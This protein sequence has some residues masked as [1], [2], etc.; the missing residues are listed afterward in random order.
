MP[1][2]R[3]S[4]PAELPTATLWS[5]GAQILKAKSAAAVHQIVVRAAAQ[6]CAAPSAVWW[7][8]SGHHLSARSTQGITLSGPARTFEAPL[9]LLKLTDGAGPAFQLSADQ[10]VHSAFLERVSAN[11]AVLVPARDGR[12]WF[13]ILSVHDGVFDQSRLDLLA[14]LAQQAAIA[15]RSLLLAAEARQLARERRSGAGEFGTAFMSALSLDE[16]LSVICR[17]SGGSGNVD[18]CLIFFAEDKGAPRLRAHLGDLGASPDLEAALLAVADSV[19]R[20]P[21]GLVVWHEGDASRSAVRSMLEG[22][23]FRSLLGLALSIRGE[24]LGALLLLRKREQGFSAHQQR[25]LLLFATQAAVAIENIQ[26]FEST[27]RRLLEVADL[28]WVG[29]RI[30]ASHDVSTIAAVVGDAAA[31][32]LDAP[33]VALFLEQEDGRF[34]AIPRSGGRP[35]GDGLVLDARGHIGAEALLAASPLAIAD[36]EEEGRTHDPLVELL[37]ARALLC[38][39]MTVQHGLRGFFVIA[40]DRPRGFRSHD[41]GVLSNYSNQAALALQSAILYQDTVRH[42]NGLSRLFDVSRSLAS[43]LDLSENLDTVLRSAAELLQAPV[44]TVMLSDSE[45]G[46]LIVKAAHGLSADD[47]LYERIRPGEGLAGRA[48][49]TGVPL[50]SADLSRDGRFKFRQRA[51]EQGLRTAIAAPLIARGRPL[52]VLNLYRTTSGEFTEDDKRLL[53]SLADSAAVAIENAGLYREAQERADFLSAMMSEINHRI[54]N[55]LQAIAGLLRMEL[56]R[57]QVSADSAIRRGISRIQA[58]AVVH[59]LM[60]ARELQFVDMKQVARRIFEIMCQSIALQCPVDS[61]VTGARVTLPSQKA[62]SVALIFAELIENA[63]RHGLAGIEAGRVSI[64]LAEGGGDVVIYVK[65]NGVG[66]PE[67]FDLDADAGFGLRIVRGLVEEE[68]NGHLEIAS[69]NGLLV[70]FRFPKV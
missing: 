30:A 54:R 14:A 1:G 44:C 45:T 42:L 64:G 21:K 43:S 35:E 31:K 63:L 38:A 66:L 2:R 7:E 53:T 26:L 34:E 40:D 48:F 67:G 57:P 32:T 37:Q 8:L 56:D 6:L 12:R 59:E 4:R 33:K 60:R 47:E 52:G 68:L 49:L 3:P 23:P 24:P 55:T 70:R 41:V 58:I 36:A 29:T 9:D 51:R 19:R 28:N 13:G 17:A 27:Q 10:T 25:G 65:D 22:T 61:V 46:D 62:T 11:T 50:T 15:L 5:A 69:G 16:L 20:D 39:P 18:A